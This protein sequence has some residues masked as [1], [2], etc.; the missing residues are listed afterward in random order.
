MLFSVGVRLALPVVALL[1][2]VDVALALLGRLNCPTAIA[3]PGLSRQDADGTAA[4]ELGLGHVSAHHAR[5]Q[6]H[7]MVAAHRVLGL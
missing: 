7:A 6:R 5:D 4:L 2:M 1:V 3:E